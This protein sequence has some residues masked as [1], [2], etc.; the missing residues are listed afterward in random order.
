MTY[1]TYD[2][3]ISMG[4]TLLHEECAKKYIELASYDIDN[5]TFNRINKIGFD[6]LTEFQ[7]STIKKVVMLQADFRS[8]NEDWLN[9]AISQYSINGVNINYGN[10]KTISVIN[11]I[12]IPTN[13]FAIL[14]QTGLCSLNLR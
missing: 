12:F 6:N 4:G 8:D 2:D 9:S 1:I 13:V 11:G 3:Y 14:K 5:L 10:S 7:K